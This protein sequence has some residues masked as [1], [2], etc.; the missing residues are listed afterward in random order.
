MV[1][2]WMA[3]TWQRRT[4]LCFFLLALSSGLAVLIGVTDFVAE[5]QQLHDDEYLAYW[6]CRQTAVA[7]SALL[8]P[9]GIWRLLKYL[10]RVA[11]PEVAK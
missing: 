8:F 5:R 3:M 2:Y 6:Y 11:P 10:N 9:W 7:I 4:D 1:F